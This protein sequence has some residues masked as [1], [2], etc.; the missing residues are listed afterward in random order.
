[1]WLQC[2]QRMFYLGPQVLASFRVA[3]H[4]VNHHY[5]NLELRPHIPNELEYKHKMVFS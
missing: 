1:M 2:A 4:H 3:K 5:Y